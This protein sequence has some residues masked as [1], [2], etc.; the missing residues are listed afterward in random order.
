MS[1]S[2][3]GLMT[4][5]A[6]VDRARP[7]RYPSAM[8]IL[9]NPVDVAITSR[10]SVRAFLDT[11]VPLA[12]VTH[13]LEVAA[14]APSGT[15]MQPW[16]VHVLAGAARDAFCTAL[17]DAFMARITDDASEWQYYPHPLFEP[18]I[19][20]RR[21][22]GW[23]LYGLL[24]LG[25]GDREKIRRQHA[26]NFLFF[27]APVGMICTIDRRL[28]IGSWLDYGMFLQNITI[29]ARGHGLHT[30]P[31]AIFSEYPRTIRKL[32]GLSDEEVIV[33][34]MALGHID[35]TAPENTLITDREPVEGFATFA[36][37]TNNG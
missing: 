31:Q 10:H 30:C 21:K 3:P 20:R 4:G 23:D 18:Y 32:L 19:S 1:G 2:Q 26:R 15:N 5:A 9:P 22:V 11:P 27:G 34:G 24:G 25:R 37:F 14:R 28:M 7:C 12:L 8:T 35:P 33:C 13:L 16:R 6:G 36:G 17:H 29:A